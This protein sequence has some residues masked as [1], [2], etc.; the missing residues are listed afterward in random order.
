MSCGLAYWRLA[1]HGD[2]L[3]FGGSRLYGA[4]GPGGICRLFGARRWL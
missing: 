1:M 3:F 4:Q 2:G